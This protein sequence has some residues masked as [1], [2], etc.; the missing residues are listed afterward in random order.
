MCVRAFWVVFCI[1]YS[2]LRT[3]LPLLVGPQGPCGVQGSERVS[4]K[5]LYNKNWQ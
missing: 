1:F 5:I 4:H 2:I 3:V